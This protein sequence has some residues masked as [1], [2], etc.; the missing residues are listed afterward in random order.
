ML[1]PR[2]AQK[3][4]PTNFSDVPIRQG[5]DMLTCRVSGIFS[6]LIVQSQLSFAQKAAVEKNVWRGG[7]WFRAI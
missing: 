2:K 6:V 1:C 4:S 5:A 7:F 3:I